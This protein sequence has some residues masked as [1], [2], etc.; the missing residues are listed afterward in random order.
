MGSMSLV[1][2]VIV[3][4]IVLMVFGPTRLG[5]IG[6]TLGKGVRNVRE[7]LAKDAEEENARGRPPPKDNSQN[8]PR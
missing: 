5:A 6:K 1:H 2:W 4:I 3:L 8:P 7:R